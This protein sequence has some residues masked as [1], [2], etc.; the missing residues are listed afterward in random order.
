MFS[1]L[2]CQEVID[3]LLGSGYRSNVFQLILI[4]LELIISPND[5]VDQALMQSVAS[6]GLAQQDDRALATTSRECIEATDHERAYAIHPEVIEAYI[7]HQNAFD[8]HARQA[9][10]AGSLKAIGE[11]AAI[12]KAKLDAVKQCQKNG[13][14][15]CRNTLSCEKT[16][17]ELECDYNHQKHYYDK[18]L[19]ASQALE[20][21]NKK[22][23]ETRS[24][25]KKAKDDARRKCRNNQEIND[26]T[27]AIVE[28]KG[29]KGISEFFKDRFLRIIVNRV[30]IFEKDAEQERAGDPLKI[31]RE[32][33]ELVEAERKKNKRKADKL[34]ERYHDSLKS[35]KKLVEAERNKNKRKADKLP[36]RYDD[37]LKGLKE[38][39]EAEKNKSRKKQK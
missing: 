5:K 38:L 12:A 30:S 24:T 33:V 18:S 39:V 2:D 11:N 9:M 4:N 28:S 36:E 17:E 31:L 23:E 26:Q 8:E 7:N 13:H 3:L 27:L 1:I 19:K 21:A 35:P 15:K 29:F 32:F 6:I 34:H 25:L 14:S 20:S 37:P 10:V 16:L 22:K